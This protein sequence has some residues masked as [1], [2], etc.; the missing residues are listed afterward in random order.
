MLPS[1]VVLGIGAQYLVREL[2]LFGSVVQPLDHTAPMM[3]D[4][5]ILGLI[6]DHVRN[7]L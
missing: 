7:I 3:P 5:V 4:L 6:A 1:V 2:Q